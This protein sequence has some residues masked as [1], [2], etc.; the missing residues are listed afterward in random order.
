[1]RRG[2][3]TGDDKPFVVVGVDLFVVRTR[4]KPSVTTTAQQGSGGVTADKMGVHERPDRGAPF[5]FA[6]EAR[7]AIEELRRASPRT[8]KRFID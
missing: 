4:P 2:E 6:L 3:S 8:K 1:M 7:L 5:V